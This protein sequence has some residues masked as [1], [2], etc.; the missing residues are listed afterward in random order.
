ML[1]SPERSASVVLSSFWITSRASSSI[2]TARAISRFAAQ[3]FDPF[4]EQNGTRAVGGEEPPLRQAGQQFFQPVHNLSQQAGCGKPELP[5]RE[6]RTGDRAQLFWKIFRPRGKVD[7]DANHHILNRTAL[8]I[9]GGFGENPADFPV[10]QIKVVDPFDPPNR[11]RRAP[12]PL[13]RLPLRP[14][15]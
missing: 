11:S 15:P 8:K 2:A 6:K 12:A 14:Q 13:R 7:P 9:G 1:I 10:P 4:P 3:H 5:F